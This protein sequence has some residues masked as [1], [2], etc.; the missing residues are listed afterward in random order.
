MVQS[1]VE[2]L[3]ALP[4]AWQVIL[5]AMIPV[6]E[7]RAAIPLGLA[8]NLPGVEVFWLAVVG[9]LI[10]VVPL[11]FGLPVVIRWM[12]RYRFCRPVIERLVARARR[13]E[14]QVQRYGPWGLLLFVGVPA[15]GTGVWV[16]SL[17]AVLLG[18]TPWRAMAAMAGGVLLAGMLVTLFSLGMLQLAHLYGLETLLALILLAA[19]GWW[20]RRSQSRG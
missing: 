14:E 16:G 20:W 2:T 4:P 19:A 7:L 10:P 13:K 9:N 15:P 11:L 12:S 18:I 8:R 5:L 1:M 6:A 3:A 17:V